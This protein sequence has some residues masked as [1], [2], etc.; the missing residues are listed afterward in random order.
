MIVWLLAFLVHSSL[1]LTLALLLTRLFPSM[2]ARMRETIWYTA[3]VTSLF[4]PSIH[5]FAPES[6]ASL[7]TLPLPAHLLSSAE[8]GLSAVSTTVGGSSVAQPPRRSAWDLRALMS[9]RPDWV[10]SDKQS[11]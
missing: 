3:I 2:H 11:L 4:V 1:W 6:F 10:Y 7:W 5:A 9:R 8:P